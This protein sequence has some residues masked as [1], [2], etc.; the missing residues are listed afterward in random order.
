MP[1]M[2]N[3]MPI[4]KNWQKTSKKYNLKD[5]VAVGLVCGA[6]SKNVEV[7]DIDLKYDVT[8]NL[9]AR[10]KKL[11]NEIDPSLLKKL[12]VQKTR[13]GGYHFI[14]RCSVIKGNLKLA[15]RRITDEEKI[16]ELSDLKK[17]FP[18]EKEEVLLK[19]IS[20]VKVLLETRGEGGYVVCYPS[21][22]YE[23]VFGDYYSINE[24]TPEQRDT[25]H[26]I[27]RQFNEV[28]EE[29][30]PVKYENR[31]KLKG[32]SPFEDYNNRGDVISLL[33]KHGWKIVKRQGNKT[34]VLRP[35]STTSQT[36]GNFDHD[37][38]WF[39]VFTTSS[40]F[41][42]MQA[43]QPYAVY[44]VLE[45]NKDFQLASKKLYDEGYGDRKEVEREINAKVPSRI[46]LIDSDY[47][48]VAKPDD[49]EE[50]LQQVRTGTLPMG[51][52]TGMPEMD[53]HFLFKQGNMVIVNGI[54]NVGKTK[55]ILFLAM[56]SALFHGWKWIIYSSEN[57]LGNVIRT[58]IE[59]YT[60]KKLDKVND[61]LYKE[62]KD[63]VE[64][65]FTILKA[66]EAL[67]N[68]R[69]I[70][71]MTKK[72]LNKQQYNSCLIDPYNSLK[73][74]LTNSS[75]LNTHEFHYEAISELKMYGLK[76][77]FGWY[78]NMHAVT[79]AIRQKDADGYPSPPN[80]EDTEGGGKFSN[81]ADEFLTVHRRTQ[82]P[83]EWMITDVYVRKVKE[84][85]T[86]GKPTP[87]NQPIRL[88]MN[89]VGVGFS[90]LNEFGH[91]FDPINSWKSKLG[92]QS[93]MDYEPKLWMP[94]KDENGE[95]SPF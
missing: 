54:D 81:K 26:N 9:F 21:K 86:G 12:V 5:C 63:F 66:D 37:K 2:E 48:F 17:Q 84:W 1:V 76:E 50:Y 29:Y 13:S 60:G 3:K 33:E 28:M 85:E 30:R 46:S 89:N 74:E 59:F 24:I 57:T 18:N 53:K 45:C 39:S 36:S 69:D 73:I 80:K 34:L 31:Q 77:K 20:K 32:I 92:K 47:S 65:H 40:E 41:E 94:Y 82:H 62:A 64:K 87:I 67:F 93:E 61:S 83:T 70:I 90:E 14:Y 55:V 71:N 79:S 11:I 35:G 6:L 58:L 16:K 88:K 19:R 22:G 91:Q 10:Y 72:L 43:Y 25:L 44:A 78:I 38:N 4:E 23:L 52:T 7:I 49:Y 75:K 42:P 8:G 95:E 15:Q 56:L 27:A 68:Y 51:L